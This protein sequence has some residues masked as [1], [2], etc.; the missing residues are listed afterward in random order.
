MLLGGR[1][2][3]AW[4]SCYF[5]SACLA[6]WWVHSPTFCG[7]TNTIMCQLC[8][9]IWLLK[10]FPLHFLLQGVRELFVDYLLLFYFF[11]SQSYTTFFYP[12]VVIFFCSFVLWY[13][14]F[15]LQ[16]LS[17]N[18][19]LSFFPDHWSDGKDILTVFCHFIDVWEYIAW[20]YIFIS[21]VKIAFE[22]PWYPSLILT[23]VCSSSSSKES[24]RKSCWG[25]SDSRDRAFASQLPL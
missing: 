9:G 23:C 7:D 12:N 21:R 4:A 25:R 17:P 14:F 11:P 5:A 6:G 3:T 24:V 16:F 10:A 18:S 15:L 1:S 22:W 20:P 13:C 8:C 19:Y 2:G